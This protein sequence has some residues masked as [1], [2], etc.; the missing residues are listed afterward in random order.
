KNKR[1]EYEALIAN[2]YSKIEDAQIRGREISERCV[3]LPVIPEDYRTPLALKTMMKYIMNGQA[4]TW[5]ESSLQYDT[6]YS[7]W[8]LEQNSAEAIEIQK[9][10]AMMTEVAAKRA[11]QAATAATI[12]VVSNILSWF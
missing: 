12:S 7:R 3:I 11:G 1:K 5:K 10:T 6:Q 2:E 8:I 9:Y 4:D